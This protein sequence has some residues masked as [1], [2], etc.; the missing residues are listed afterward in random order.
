MLGIGGGAVFKEVEAEA[1][2]ALERIKIA[3]CSTACQRI[4]LA[5]K[6]LCR[7]IDL[8]PA[9]GHLGPANGTFPEIVGTVR[10]GVAIAVDIDAVGLAVPGSD[11]RL[12]IAHK[13][14]GIDL[15]LHPVGHLIEHALGG[16]IAFEG[17]AHFDDVKVNGAGRDRLLQA[18]VVVGLGQVDP[19]DLGAGIGLPRLEEA[20]EQEVVQVLVVQAQ[21]SQFHAREFA[22]GDI[23]LGGAQGQL[24]DLLPI[25]IGGGPHADTRNL[26]YLCADVILRKDRTRAGPKAKAAQGRKAADACCTLQKPPAGHR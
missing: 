5:D 23:R 22:F 10:K 1:T 26:Q 13:V 15:R 25:G 17:G 24:A 9:L 19:V 12:E 21:E 14:F 16:C 4:D 7:G 18:R 6:R 2:P 3:V 11:R 20:T 8:L